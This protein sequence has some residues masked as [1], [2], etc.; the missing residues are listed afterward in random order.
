M[1][2][3]HQIQRSLEISATPEAVWA[4][5]EDSTRLPEWAA[6]V[7]EVTCRVPGREAVGSVR[8][9]RVDFAGRTGT[10]VERCVELIPK[11]K[12]AYVVDD[13][14]LGFNKLFADYGFTITLEDSGLRRTTARMDTYYTPR[15]IVSAAMNS[16]LMRRK[17][18]VTVDGLLQGLQRLAEE[19]ASANRL[20]GTPSPPET[21]PSGDV[22]L[23]A[24]RS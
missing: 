19:H 10:I 3:K 8:E 1:N 15:N 9:C 7:E 6:V 14:S 21:N 23:G 12:V 2:G 17:F 5:L 11:T 20:A 24:A 22:T 16:V 4:I 18:A 13:D